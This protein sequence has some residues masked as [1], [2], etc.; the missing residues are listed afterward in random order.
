MMSLNSYIAN[1]REDSIDGVRQRLGVLDDSGN[2][3]VV[4]DERSCFRPTN[5]PANPG[6]QYIQ[7]PQPFRLLQQPQR[8]LVWPQN[9]VKRQQALRHGTENKEYGHCLRP[10]AVQKL[11]VHWGLCGLLQHCSVRHTQLLFCQW[12]SRYLRWLLPQVIVFL[13]IAC[14][15]DVKNGYFLTC[16]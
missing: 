1:W 5:Q 11:H 3:V 6:M 15:T 13:F 14:K 7:P 8:H 12:R 9:A 4:V 10:G 16:F 2:M